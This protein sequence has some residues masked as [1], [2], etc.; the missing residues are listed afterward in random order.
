MIDLP[1]RRIEVAKVVAT[2]SECEETIHH[3]HSLLSAPAIRQQ[4]GGGVFISPYDSEQLR[5]CS[6]DVRLGPN[7]FRCMEPSEGAVILNPYDPE[8]IRRHYSQRLRAKK[9]K[10]FEEYRC[11][12]W[13]NIDP[14]DLLIIMMPGEMILGHTMEF[15]GGTKDHKT[16]R[17]FTAE[18][19]A[20][21]S[22]G[23]VRLE[24]CRCA[25]WGDVGYVNRWTMEIVCTSPV[26]V[27]LIAGT[28]LA[29]MKFYEV[30]TVDDSELYGANARR[31]HYQF[32]TDLKAI[33]RAW[34]PEMM[35]PKLTKD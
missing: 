9:A 13:K 26:P 12:A 22:V 11:G 15:I 33:R 25:G 19:K 31:D 18:M 6:Y 34:K 14:D 35:L 27:I 1:S 5:T 16:G 20:R 8:S 7:Y 28:R 30:D 4:L 23:R 3:S 17:C 32:G 2:S 24:V 29:Q 10:T 21:S